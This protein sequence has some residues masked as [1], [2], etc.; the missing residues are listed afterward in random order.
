LT[1]TRLDILAFP[2]G[3]MD[4]GLPP[5]IPFLPDKILPHDGG[6][7]VTGMEGELLW[8][9]Q[10]LNPMGEV[11]VPH[12]MRIHH[13]TVTD[14]ALHAMW[15]DRELLLA[16]M[17]SLPLG[18]QENG[19]TRANLRTAI[20]TP[21]NHHPAG[22]RWSHSLDAEP[23]ALA[24]KGD[25]LVFE[26]YRR[27]LYSISTNAEERWRMPSPTWQYSKRR[28]RN[29]E[30]V[31]LHHLEKDF[32]IVSRGGHVQRRSTDS[33]QLLE[34]YVLEGVEGP[35]E[36]HYRHGTHELVAT[37][38]GEVYWL[39]AGNVHQRVLLSGPIQ[40]AAWDDQLPGWRIA[41]WREEVVLG[42]TV[43]DR[44]PTREIPIHIHVNGERPL[45]LFNDGT[46]ASS[47]F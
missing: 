10:T 32:I 4:E 23:M 9:D 30:T 40:H 46:W 47:Q 16:F 8:L 36:H 24:G 17:G 13:A 12:P 7:V 22:N 1:K 2:A 25:V 41:G 39:Q 31:A 28:P 27:G 21:I 19:T 6:C 29:E 45:V 35:V 18:S 33:G 20:N 43:S 14:G 3:I 11:S 38:H 26:L 34:E 44:K 5:R 37:A 15:L 42:A